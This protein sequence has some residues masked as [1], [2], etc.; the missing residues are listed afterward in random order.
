MTLARLLIVLA[1]APLFE[2]GTPDVPFTDVVIDSNNPT[3]PHCKTLGDINGDGHLDAIVASSAGGG[4]YWYEYPLWTKHAI[5]S[6]G[7][8]STDMQAG[9]INL[10][11]HVDVIVPQDTDGD[12]K[13]DTMYWFENPGGNGTGT[14]NE[15][16]IGYSGRS[17]GAH[18]VEIG[19]INNDGK[20]DVAG[21]GGLFLQGA[22]PDQWTFVDIGRG[23][24]E[25]TSLADVDGDGYLDVICPG[26]SGSVVWY[27]NPLPAGDPAVGSNWVRHTIVSG[28]WSV[29]MGITVADINGDGRADVLVANAESPGQIVWYEQPTDPVSGTWVEHV[30]GAADYVHTFK[31]ADINQDGQPDVVFA[32]MHQSAQKR[33]GLFLNNGRGSFWTLQVVATTGSHNIRVG[34]IRA[35]RHIDIFGANWNDASP[36]HA[37]V[38]LWRND[39]DLKPSLD[40]W[41]YI[42]ADSMRG[43]SSDGLGFFGLGFGDLNG[44]GY[45]DIASGTYFYLNPGGDM[46]A[47]PWSRVTLPADPANGLPLDASLLFDASSAGRPDSILA[48]DLPNIIWLKANDPQ[49][50][51]WTPQVVAQMPPTSHHNGRTVKLAHFVRGNVKPDIVLSGGG[52]TFLLQIPPNPAADIWPIVQ[53]TSTSDDEQKGIGVGDIDG[54]GNLDIAVGAGA[55]STELDWYFNPGDG[56]SNWVQ[57][58][59]GNTDLTIKMVEI[60]DINGDGRLDIVATEEANPSNIYWFEAPPTPTGTWVRHTVATGLAEVDSLSGVDMNQDGHPDIVI[61]EIFGSKRLI[62]Y[63]NGNGGGGCGSSWTEHVVDSGK[64]SHNGARAVDLDANG[65]FDII[66]IAYFTYQDLHIWRNDAKSDTR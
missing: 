31:V 3:N 43:P 58:F 34:D 47:V 56:S 37:V 22:T 45:Q 64:E 14:W 6:N 20:L 15:H 27:K 33:V 32:E 4:M 53:I 8:W 59:V 46:A 12:G 30:I 1:A 21:N 51:S 39:L 26:P 19:D 16:L 57:H 54:D 25:G 18:D 11:G 38:H 66:S 29:E 52:G 17:N 2:R 65:T 60:A 41:T 44:D 48:E 9:D 24:E 36:D 13:G 40:S 5:R 63:E 28:G 23:G 49:G 7:S 55:S 10:D 35:D 62:V 61:G 42:H 50:N